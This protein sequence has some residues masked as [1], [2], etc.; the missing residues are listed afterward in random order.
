[1][2][3]LSYT[4]RTPSLTRAFKV[5]NL[6]AKKVFDD[7]GFSGISTFGTGA[8]IGIQSGN[9][10]GSLT[11]QGQDRAQQ[12]GDWRLPSGRSDAARA[13]EFFNT[14]AFTNTTPGNYG[15][16]GR[17][18]IPTPGYWGTDLAII[19]HIPFGKEGQREV[20]IRVEGYNA[21]NHINFAGPNIFGGGNTVGSPGF[22]TANQGAV[23]GRIVQ[24]GAKVYF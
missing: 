11:G 13:A 4:Y 7:W 8:Y 16:T 20:E 2:L 17:N 15:N 24:L 10:D 9:A 22:G 3:I 12:V 5:N 23:G 19:K 1:M 6:V 14:A 18:F 21:F